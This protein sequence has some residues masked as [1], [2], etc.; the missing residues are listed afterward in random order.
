MNKRLEHLIDE[1]EKLNYSITQECDNVYD[2]GKSSPRGQDCHVSIDTEND[3]DLFIENI[4]AYV[5]DYDVSY[6]TY[7]WL[8]DEGHGSNGVPYDMKDVYE[9]MEW[10]KDSLKELANTLEILLSEY[11]LL[12]SE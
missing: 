10:W 6:E 3:A 8:D 7:L 2:I 9:D 11:D 4:R 12:E 5:S 1:V